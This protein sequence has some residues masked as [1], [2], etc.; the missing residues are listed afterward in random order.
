MQIVAQAK[1]S[2]ERVVYASRV[3]VEDIGGRTIKDSELRLKITRKRYVGCA[4]VLTNFETVNFVTQH[5]GDYKIVC[6]TVGED[7]IMCGFTH[8]QGL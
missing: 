7:V 4:I 2:K 6:I 3:H 8:Y 5:Q 1:F